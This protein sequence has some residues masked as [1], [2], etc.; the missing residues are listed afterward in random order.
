MIEVEDLVKRYGTAT[1]VDGVGFSAPAGTVTG[2]LGP[3][4]AGKTTTVKILLGLVRPDRGRALVDGRPYTSLARPLRIVGTLLEADSLHRG[5]TA[6]QHLLWLARSNRIPPERIDRRLEQ[7]GLADQARTRISAFSL[8]MRQRLGLAGAL[9]GDPKILLLDEPVNGL[10]AEGIVWMRS[11]LRDLAAR[12]T[13]VLVS[14][15]HMT[16][17][18]RTAD[19]VV[20]IGSGRVLADLPTGEL[21]SR[22]TQ[23][24]VRVTSAERERLSAVLED[25]GYAVRTSPGGGL[26]VAGAGTAE[27]G[28]LAGEHRIVLEGLTQESGSLEEAY[29]DLIGAP[30]GGRAHGTEPLA[31][32]GRRNRR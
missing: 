3:N 22:Y 12:G 21:I 32:D 24:K 8:G 28:A 29:L 2:L 18:A 25:A 14:S 7:V 17:V 26:D 1:A 31:A 13:A 27:I 5:R 15:H 10:D 16:E 30:G 23:P 11:F 4:G 19:H 6:R 9:L 20:V